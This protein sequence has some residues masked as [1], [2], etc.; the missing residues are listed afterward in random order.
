MI[1]LKLNTEPFNFAFFLENQN[2]SAKTAKEWLKNQNTSTKMSHL[3]YNPP[4]TSMTVS[5]CSRTE[6]NYTM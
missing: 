4:F 3:I 1:T 2:G 5:L 6:M